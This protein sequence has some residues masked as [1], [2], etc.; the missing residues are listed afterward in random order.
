MALLA[1]PT[2]SRREIG[3]T[4]SSGTIPLVKGKLV[5]RN[6]GDIPSFTVCLSEHTMTPDSTITASIR[7]RLAA[8]RKTSKTFWLLDHSSDTSTFNNKAT[9]MLT[10]TTTC[11]IRFIHVS[12]LDAN[13]ANPSD[14][15]PKKTAITRVAAI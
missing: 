1:Q 13:G 15:I 5:P 14:T 11:P 3:P 7:P 9:Y 10:Y 6:L 12:H 2:Q 4:T 8:T